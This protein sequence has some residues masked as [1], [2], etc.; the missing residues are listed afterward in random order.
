MKNQIHRRIAS[1]IVL[2]AFFLPL[3]H[4]FSSWVPAPALASA[5]PTLGTDHGAAILTAVPSSDAPARLD[6]DSSGEPLLSGTAEVVLQSSGAIEADVDRL[7]ALLGD[8]NNG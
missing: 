7:R 8:P 1:G 5:G 4:P 2:P 6:D 3:L